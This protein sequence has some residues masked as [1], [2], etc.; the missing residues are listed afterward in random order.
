[1]NVQ[2]A[3]L[4]SWDTFPIT[5]GAYALR[6]HSWNSS[7]DMASVVVPFS[8]GNFQMSQQSNTYQVNATGGAITYT[9]LVPFTVTE[10]IVLKDASGSVKRTLVNASRAAGTYNDAWDGRGDSGYVPD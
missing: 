2:N 5:N 3:Q 4:Y 9:S 1:S 6:L 7:G 8:I 10:T